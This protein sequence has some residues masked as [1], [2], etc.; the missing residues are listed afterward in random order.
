MPNPYLD[1][2]DENDQ[3]KSIRPTRSLQD[4][5]TARYA[6]SGARWDFGS[7]GGVAFLVYFAMYALLIT[8]A[9]IVAS[10][11]TQGLTGAI[12]VDYIDD[13]SD[14]VSPGAVILFIYLIPTLVPFV[15]GL[16]ALSAK[17][18]A[19]WAFVTII[20]SVFA[21]PTFVILGVTVNP[22][23]LVLLAAIN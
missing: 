10:D 12:D 15:F 22:T 14:T 21:N 8:V 18:G 13:N 3:I 16:I 1:D 20:L 9:M 2:S 6:K 23:W 11:S 4:K 5:R 19:N 7:A 17:K